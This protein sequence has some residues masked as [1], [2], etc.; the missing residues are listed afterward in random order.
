MAVVTQTTTA[1]ADPLTSPTAFTALSGPVAGSLSVTIATV[2]LTGTGAFNPDLA[3]KATFGD[4]ASSASITITSGVLTSAATTTVTLQADKQAGAVA[5]FSITVT[6]AA[7]SGG[8]LTFSVASVSTVNTFL[9]T[10]QFDGKNAISAVATNSTGIS[11]SFGIPE[12]T[13]SNNALA[14]VSGVTVAI[15]RGGF[16][17]QA[18]TV[19]S[20]ANSTFTSF[21]RIHN[22]GATAGVV[23]IAVINDATGA[24]LGSSFSSSTIAAGQTLQLSAANIETGAGITP[25]N[26]TNYTVNVTGPIIGYIQ[27]IIYN[28]S[29]GQLADLSS[30]RN[31]NS[32]SGNP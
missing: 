29:T 23:T 8:T 4:A 19:L 17:G 5:G 2:T 7:F 6:T 15:N 21:I 30:F 11:V 27:H 28:A 18:N 3:T 26:G 31:A 10:A 24:T 22:N 14:A 13:V 16:S 32:T 9:I 25:V 12:N 20:S 1:T